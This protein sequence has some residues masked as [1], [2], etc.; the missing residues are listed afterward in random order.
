MAAAFGPWFF[1]GVVRKKLGLSLVSEKTGK[2]RVY[3]ILAKPA[4]ALRKG[5]AGRKAA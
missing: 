1:F 5:K 4:S 2:E 3:H